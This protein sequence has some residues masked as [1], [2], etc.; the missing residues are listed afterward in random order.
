MLKKY[1][2]MLILASVFAMTVSLFAC[3]SCN[4]YS[5]NDA[6]DYY[7]FTSEQKQALQSL[8]QQASITSFPK[9][10]NKE[11][12]VSDI[13]SMLQETQKKF[14][15]RSGTQ[16]RWET[17]RLEWVN[18]NKSQILS[19]LKILGFVN[20]IVPK[21]KS[22]D[23]FCILGATAQRMADR[24]EYAN[25]L[26]KSGLSTKAIILL[27]GERY[28]TKGVDGSENNLSQM[29][30]ELGLEDYTKL[31][32]THLIQD[33][34]KKSPLHNK[35]MTVHVIDTPR[36]DLPRP[37]TQTTILKLIEWLKNHQEIQNIIF[38]SN[39]PHVEY[40]KAIIDL[41]F[42]EQY[43]NINY[44]VVGSAVNNHNDLQP[45]IEG[46]GSYLWAATPAVLSKMNIQIKDEK[47]KESLKDLY[48]K[49]PLIYKSLPA[50]FAQ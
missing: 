5:F 40:Q 16:E 12:V 7:G 38:V 44:E 50:S 21:Q 45:I 9:R 10:L 3:H 2:Y 13:I 32:E 49:N 35:A 18:K 1:S 20:N 42:K 17:K 47:I 34:F 26:V 41:I 8:F 15:A 43:V 19:D 37:T 46:L 33:E 30:K 25:F 29:A 48:S 14:V 36:G 23:A 11:E 22:T 24:I 39:Q 27:A 6:L 31:T 28:V 4:Q